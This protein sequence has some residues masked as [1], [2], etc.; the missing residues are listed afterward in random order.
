MANILRRF[1]FD[2]KLEEYKKQEAEKLDKLEIEEAKKLIK[3][4]SKK[5]NRKIERRNGE[6]KRRK[7]KLEKKV[8]RI[9]SIIIITFVSQRKPQ[10]FYIKG[11]L[12]FV[13]T[14]GNY[15]IKNLKIIYFFK[16]FGYLFKNHSN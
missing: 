8:M 12:R 1:Q 5:L 9:L 11:I 13:R 4:E 16:R 7:W 14:N 15:K 10:A 2:E 3:A 6:I